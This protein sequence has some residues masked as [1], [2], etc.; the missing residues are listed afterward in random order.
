MTSKNCFKLI[1]IGEEHS[2]THKKTELLQFI[3]TL[4]I[5]NNL[6]VCFFYEAPIDSFSDGEPV[7]QHV[8]PDNNEIICQALEPAIQNITINGE[9]FLEQNYPSILT[10]V[11]YFTAALVDFVKQPTIKLV[12]LILP[13]TFE[14]ICDLDPRNPKKLEFRQKLR[15]LDSLLK[16]FKIFQDDMSYI[17]LC[18]TKA[19]EILSLCQTY[20]DELCQGN[21][22]GTKVNELFENFTNPIPYLQN[23]RNI[24]MID[25]I[26]KSL[27]VTVCDVVVMIVGNEHIDDIQSILSSTDLCISSSFVMQFL[28]EGIEPKIFTDIEAF[29]TPSIIPQS[30]TDSSLLNIGDIVIINNLEKGKQYNGKYA[31]ITDITSDPSRLGVKIYKDFE[32]KVLFP[33][34]NDKSVSIKKTNMTKLDSLKGG[35]IKKYKSKKYTKKNYTKKNYKKSKRFKKRKTCCKQNK[36]Y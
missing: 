27:H 1:L 21:P 22:V 3:K 26:K 24:I 30:V 2:V 7:R 10:D 14:I 4:T 23:L 5:K 36:K 18:K 35:R 20:L 19:S 34:L 11:L 8:G 33:E 9:L 13:R 31:V 32:S 28:K 17:T 12:H 15:E 25:T 16:D 29:L 6:K